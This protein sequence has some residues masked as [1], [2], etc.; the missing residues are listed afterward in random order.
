MLS[1]KTSAHITP[2]GNHML[3]KMFIR[4]KHAM[5]VGKKKQK[6]SKWYIFYKKWKTIQIDIKFESKCRFS[7]RYHLYPVRKYDYKI[8]FLIAALHLNTIFF[9]C[10]GSVRHDNK[11]GA[12]KCLCC[13]SAAAVGDTACAYISAQ[14]R[15]GRPLCPHTYTTPAQTPPPPLVSARL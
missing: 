2:L 12:L 11:L 1:T 5:T 15:G 14:Y 6:L 3:K 13:G 4:F 8:V 9:A 10:R 7:W